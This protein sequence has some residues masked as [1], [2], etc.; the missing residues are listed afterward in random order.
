MKIYFYSCL[1]D[2]FS[3]SLNLNQKFILDQSFYVEFLM[4]HFRMYTLLKY[5]SFLNMYSDI[6]TV[7]RPRISDKVYFYVQVI[8]YR[9]KSSEITIYYY[10]R[11]A[12]RH[13]K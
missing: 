7:I 8:H 5:E 9:M 2:K 1:F 4:K 6:S 11:D 12:Q 13:Q 10:I 3:R